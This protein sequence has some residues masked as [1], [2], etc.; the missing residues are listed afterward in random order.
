[1]K[2]PKRLDLTRSCFYQLP[3]DTANIIGYELMYRAKYPGIF[4]IR[5]GTTFFFELQNAQ[6]RDAFLNSLEVSCRQ[7]GLIT[8]RTTLY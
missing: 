6:A 7:S 2:I 3:D 4:K 1:M 8:Q 5:S